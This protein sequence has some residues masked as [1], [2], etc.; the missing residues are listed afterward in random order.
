[1]PTKWRWPS[2]SKSKRPP[3]SHC[4]GCVV[5]V[6]VSLQWSQY[7][8][9]SAPSPRPGFA[10]ERAS[11]LVFTEGIEQVLGIGARGVLNDPPDTLFSMCAYTCAHGHS[12]V[13]KSVCSPSNTKC[14]FVCAAQR[15]RSRHSPDDVPQYH[16]AVGSCLK[17]SGRYG[18]D[19]GHGVVVTCRK[20]TCEEMLVCSMGG[21]GRQGLPTGERARMR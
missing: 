21:E 1:M 9:K 11:Q 15:V 3:A 16:N 4:R 14:S 18:Q 19:L 12:R 10:V 17:H 6:Q 13:N 7:H 5:C 20:L 8:S 2:S